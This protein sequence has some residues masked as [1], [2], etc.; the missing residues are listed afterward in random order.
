MNFGGELFWGCLKSWRS[1]AEEVAGKFS[2]MN[3]L[4]ILLAIFLKFARPTSN[5]KNNP[6]PR[7]AEPRDQTFQ[8]S[9]GFAVT[10]N[11]NGLLE[12]QQ[13]Y[14]SYRAILVAIASQNSF[15][16]VFMGYRTILVR[17]IAQ[18]GIAQ[19]R[20]CEKGGYRTIVGEC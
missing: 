11:C 9:I 4:R 14:F 5:K 10:C 18:W 12:A 7:S 2:R 6:N 16:L 3:S 17:Y 1:K 13:R 15:V 8:F 19:M 20:L